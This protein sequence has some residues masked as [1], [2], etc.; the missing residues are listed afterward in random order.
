VAALYFPG[1]HN[2][3]VRAKID[4]EVDGEGDAAS[5]WMPPSDGRLA[6]VKTEKEWSRLIR[7]QPMTSSR[8]RQYATVGAVQAESS[9]PIV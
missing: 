7:D 8:K 9:W 4:Y 3:K 2:N 1:M 6:E 5:R